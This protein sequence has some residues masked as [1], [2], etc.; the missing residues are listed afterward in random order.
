MRAWIVFMKELVDGVRDRRSLLSAMAFPLIAPVLSVGLLGAMVAETTKDDKAPDGGD[1]ALA[2]V[3]IEAAPSLVAYLDDNG[4]DP[5][6]YPGESP[7]DDVRERESKVILRLA[8]DYA[9]D[10]TAGRPARVELIYDAS[11]DDARS[12]V[13]KVRRTVEAWGMTTGAKRLIA[14]GVAPDVVRAVS[15]EDVDLSTAEERGARLL[16]LIP[17]FII[18]A[19]FLCSMYVAIDATAGERERGSLEA[20]VLTTVSPRELALAKFGAAFI[21]GGIGVVL[22]AVL[23]VWAIRFVDLDA[24]GLRIAAGPREAGMFLLICLPLTAVAAALQVLVA[25]FSRSFKEAQTYLS[26]MVLLPLA[27]G[28]LMTVKPVQEAAWMMAVPALGQQLMMG[29]V[30]QGSGL[31]AL[32]YALSVGAGVFATAVCVVACGRLLEKEQIIFGR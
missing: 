21:F 1:P 5:V 11:R 19:C 30:L 14:M 8:D 16:Q 17:M 10:W 29:S 25:T 32:D 15:L 3:G 4:F 24:L 27:P 12:R 28:F 6:A 22:T 13:R 2:V 31:P 23:S 7:E 9:E 20:L 26:M 18:M